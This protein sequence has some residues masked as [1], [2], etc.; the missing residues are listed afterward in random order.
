[1]SFDHQEDDSGHLSDEE[2][3]NQYEGRKV[4]DIIDD[5][6]LVATSV[7]KNYNRSEKSWNGQ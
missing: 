5:A 7:Q 4:Y 3:S 2:F 6:I 1:M